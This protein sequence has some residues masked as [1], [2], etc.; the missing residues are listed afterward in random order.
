MFVGCAGIDIVG[1]L[2]VLAD[3]AIW[4]IVGIDSSGREMLGIYSEVVYPYHMTV[5]MIVVSTSFFFHFSCN[6][7]YCN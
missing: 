2:S 1:H 5:H 7:L 4:V 3:F 6:H